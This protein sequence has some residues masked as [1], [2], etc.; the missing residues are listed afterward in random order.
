M[1]FQTMSKQRRFVLIASVIGVVSIFLPWI[2]VE[3]LGSNFGSANGFHGKGVIMF[4]AFAGAGVICLLNDQTKP[5]DKTMWLVTLALG[6]LN[7]LLAI[8]FLSDISQA[9]GLV[10]FGFWIALAASIA[11]PLF[12]WMYR[13]PGDTLQ[14]GFDSLKQNMQSTGGGTQSSSQPKSSKM[15]ELEKLIDL[16]NQG[17]ITEEEYQQLKSKIM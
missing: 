3:F 9:L 10:G 11:V 17:K 5:L 16:K 13:A 4:L 14:S 15:D 8:I 12:T 1:N 6:A 7:L 2:S